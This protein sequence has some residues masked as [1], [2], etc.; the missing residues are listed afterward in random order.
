VREAQRERGGY[1]YTLVRIPTPPSGNAGESLAEM[2]GSPPNIARNPPT[3]HSNGSVA[4]PKRPPP[5]KPP[6]IA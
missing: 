3:V 5:A 6:A 4:P 2:P 1:V